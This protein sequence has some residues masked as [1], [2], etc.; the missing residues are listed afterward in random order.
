MR[1]DAIIV[2][3]DGTLADRANRSPFGWDS[4]STDLPIYPTIRLV[5]ALAGESLVLYVT[6]RSEVCRDATLDWLREHVG[7]AGPLFMRRADDNRRDATL[8]GELFR[9]HIRDSYRVW[10]VLDDRNQTVAMW[11]RLGLACFQVSAGDF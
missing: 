2:D 11:R 8:K 10:M 1:P 4:A 9:K 5:Q 3:I 7:V 6:G